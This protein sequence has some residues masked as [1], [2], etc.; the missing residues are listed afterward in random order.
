ML[1]LQK[2][3]MADDQ[4]AKALG[5]IAGKFSQVQVIDP[6]AATCALQ[7]Q[8][9][10]LLAP[11]NAKAS[12]SGSFVTA[13]AV[14]GHWVSVHWR[15]D[16]P[17]VYAWTS[18]PRPAMLQELDLLHF[19]FG[20]AFGFGV[21]AFRF[22]FGVA[23]DV[24][25]GQCGAVAMCDLLCHLRG[26]EALPTS[27][28]THV[29]C[30]LVHDHEGLERADWVRS[31][32][33]LAG[34]ASST[35]SL[36]VQGLAGILK[37]KGV[38]PDECHA[39]AQADIQRLSP[40]VVQEAMLSGSPWR[41]LKQAASNISP[42][43]RWVLPAELQLQIQARAAHGRP[44]SSQKK[45]KRKAGRET[46]ASHP[47]AFSQGRSLPPDPKACI[48]RTPRFACPGG[49]C[50]VSGFCHARAS[51]LPSRVPG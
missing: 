12:H 30:Q 51:A 20:K 1:Q 17:R 31:P 27:A 4:V 41:Q 2:G 10:E 43:F 23:R 18:D 15:V 8:R 9:H 38:P 49:N 47:R 25:P 50:Y 46:V 6:V 44:V 34:A 39:R 3:W 5:N 45:S 37:D 33:F 29:T 21:G 32:L 42:P 14:L 7:F 24:L 40:S 19:L 48:F 35:M 28:A 11:V 16:G 26:E 13:V 22:F 36:L